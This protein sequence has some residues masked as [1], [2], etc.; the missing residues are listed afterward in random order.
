MFTNILDSGTLSNNSGTAIDE[1]PA[2]K[3]GSMRR[4]RRPMLMATFFFLD[5]ETHSDLQFT[6]NFLGDRIKSIVVNE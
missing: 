2:E 6:S 1:T 5:M 3:V 4:S